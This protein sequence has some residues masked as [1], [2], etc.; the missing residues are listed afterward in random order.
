MPPFCPGPAFAPEII[1]L[2]LSLHTETFAA[3]SDAI[4]DLAIV[5]VIAGVIYDCSCRLESSLGPKLA[6]AQP[7]APPA[8]FCVD[9]FHTYMHNL[10]RHVC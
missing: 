8:K 6:E 4:I 5:Y 9:W 7:G 10:V 1:A 3:F 2:S